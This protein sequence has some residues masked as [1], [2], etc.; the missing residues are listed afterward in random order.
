MPLDRRHT[1]ADWLVCQCGNKPTGLGF[2]PCSGA[3]EVYSIND[4]LPVASGSAW[5]GVHYLCRQCFA[6]YNVDTLEQAGT[7]SEEVQAS[8][9]LVALE[10]E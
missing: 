4:T 8:N 1:T 6:I 3:G 5:D 10:D 7:A 2:D 9:Q